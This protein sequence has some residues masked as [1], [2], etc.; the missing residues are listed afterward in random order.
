MQP[1]KSFLFQKVK[2]CEGLYL[3]CFG[4]KQFFGA[5][6]ALELQCFK[7]FKPGRPKPRYKAPCFHIIKD[8]IN[9]NISST[10]EPCYLIFCTIFNLYKGNKKKKIT[11][12]RAIF[13]ELQRF[14]TFWVAHM[15]I[16]VAFWGKITRNH[17]TLAP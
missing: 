15:Y 7:C 14:H 3:K 2:F 6:L 5:V 17:I 13:E 12:I 10:I 8:Y 16:F 4:P 9:S 11:E 1:K